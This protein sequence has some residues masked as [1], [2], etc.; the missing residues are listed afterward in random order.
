M[1]SIQ[2]EEF[3]DILFHLRIGEFP[4]ILFYVFILFAFFV[5]ELREKKRKKD[6]G[7]EVMSWGREAFESAFRKPAFLYGGLE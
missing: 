7:M 3:M 4:L 5:E 6:D 2:I 1:E